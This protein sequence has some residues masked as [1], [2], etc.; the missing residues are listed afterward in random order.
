MRNTANNSFSVLDEHPLLKLKLQNFCDDH[1]LEG[2]PALIWQCVPVRP[3][4]IDVRKKA[5]A[6]ILRQGASSDDAD[7]W[8]NAFQTHYAV[9]STFDGIISTFRTEDPGWASEFHSD[10]HII[11]GVWTFPEAALA[12]KPIPVLMNFYQNAFEDFGT[13]VSRLMDSLPMDFPVAITC[14]L[15]R[16]NA[17]G[18][19]RERQRG[20][21]RMIRRPELQWRVRTAG[22]KVELEAASKVMGKELLW[23]Y[24]IAAS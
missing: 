14:T 23:A 7:G 2:K 10:G 18:F 20:E 9:E 15:L 6:E 8:W 3:V 11:A 17:L 24:N 12:D 21:I 16:A 13:L 5:V 4:E 19:Q 22:S 1:A